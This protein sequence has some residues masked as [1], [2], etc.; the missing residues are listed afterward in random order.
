M[1]ASK[2]VIAQ[3]RV[4]DRVS[5]MAMGLSPPVDAEQLALLRRYGQE[6]QTTARQV[7]FREGDRARD[8]MV[9]LSGAVTVVDHDGGVERQL[10]TIGAGRFVAELNILTGERVFA[11]VV[12]SEPGSVLVVP[13]DSLQEVIAQDQ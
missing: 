13:A 3:I 12:V 8:F 1:L 2:R 7:L 4:P 9:I 11:T 10:V 6:Q 5:T